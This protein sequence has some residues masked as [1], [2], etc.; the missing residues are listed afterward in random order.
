MVEVSEIA[1][2]AMRHDTVVALAF[3]RALGIAAAP[4]ARARRAGTR[5][6]RRYR[7]MRW[8]MEN[9]GSPMDGR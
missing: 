6:E 3:R 9:H 7:G 8:C 5:P 2:M 1:R 4:A